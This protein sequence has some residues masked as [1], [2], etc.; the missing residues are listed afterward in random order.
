MEREELEAV[1]DVLK[2]YDIIVV[3]DELYGEL[4]YTG[5]PH[6]SVVEIEGMRDRTILIGGF[7]KAFSSLIQVMSVLLVKIYG[8]FVIFCSRPGWL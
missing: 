8:F 1:C 7:S 6:V 5:K 2:R 4:T 3:S